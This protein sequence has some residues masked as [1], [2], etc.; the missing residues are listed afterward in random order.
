[1][2]II[3]AVVLL[4]AILL[5]PILLIRFRKRW[6]ADRC[7]LKDNGVVS[8]I[9]SEMKLPNEKTRKPTKERTVTTAAL[10]VCGATLI[11]AVFGGNGLSKH[12]EITSRQSRSWNPVQV[13]N[14]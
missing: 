7:I 13:K 11:E 5:A 2:P 9:M 6:V 1:M 8:K 14:K 10:P 4:L 12:A 3:T